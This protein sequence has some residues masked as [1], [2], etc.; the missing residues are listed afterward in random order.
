MLYQYVDFFPYCNELSDITGLSIDLV[1]MIVTKTF[2]QMQ[3]GKIDSVDGF[4]QIEDELGKQM[5]FSGIVIPATDTN[6]M[7]KKKVCNM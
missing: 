6:D 7:M 5:M 2:K 3:A 1:I 4:K